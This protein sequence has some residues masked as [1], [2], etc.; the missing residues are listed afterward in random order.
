MTSHSYYRR[1]LSM[2]QH[3]LHTMEVMLFLTL[4]C[5]TVFAAAD[6]HAGLENKNISPLSD[7]RPLNSAGSEPHH[8]SS[9]I[10]MMDILDVHTGVAE[11]TRHLL[12]YSAIS[13]H[14]NVDRARNVSLGCLAAFAKSSVPVTGKLII[15]RKVL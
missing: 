3:L 15:C 10:D 5:T 12:T 9:A 2:H 6:I 8:Q 4:L 14:S 13:S 7:I 1:T 11:L